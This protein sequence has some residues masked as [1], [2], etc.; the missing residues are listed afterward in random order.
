VANL[1]RIIREIDRVGTVRS[2]INWL[3]ARIADGVEYNFF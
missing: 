3:I 2:N 1:L